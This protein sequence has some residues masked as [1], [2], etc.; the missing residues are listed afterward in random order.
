VE[1]IFELLLGLLQLIFEVI[2]QIILEAIF[3]LGLHCVKEP[4]RRPAPLHPV[5]ATGGYMI[6]GAIAGA[7]SLWLFPNSF[8]K[9]EGF[10]VANLVLTP[11]IAGG[12]MSAIGMWRSKRRQELIRLDRFGYGF[13]FALAMA[14]IRFHWAH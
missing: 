5:L 4:F 10:R 3:E 13:A 2:L 7:I 6:F 11:I 9:S 12:A 1:I 14:A 8:I